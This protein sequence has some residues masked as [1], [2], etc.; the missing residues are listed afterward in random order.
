[1]RQLV[2]RRCS[3][4]YYYIHISTATVAIGFCVC[5]CAEFLFFLPYLWCG[6]G[7]VPRVSKLR[8][9]HGFH[10]RYESAF[11]FP[12]EY[13][14]Y[15]RESGYCTTKQF[16]FLSC[17]FFFF[18]II[19]IV[20]LFPRFQILNETTWLCVYIFSVYIY[21]CVY[22][23]G[24]KRWKISIY[25]ILFPVFI[26]AFRMASLAFCGFFLRLFVTNNNVK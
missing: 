17:F 18:C 12:R 25:N 19:T 10:T 3:V 8:F 6:C 15:F 23:A 26:H 11:L 9:S 13:R 14:Q 21:A 7:D 24:K 1:M 22:T 5:N 2:E 16:F 4:L 20:C